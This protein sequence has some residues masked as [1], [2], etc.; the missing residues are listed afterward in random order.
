MLAAGKMMMSPRAEFIS[1]LKQIFFGLVDDT[2]ARGDFERWVDDHS[3]D[4][5]EFLPPNL[6]WEI[7]SADYTHENKYLDVMTKLA[8]WIDGSPFD[9]W[10]LRRLLTAIIMD[11]IDIV[12]AARELCGLYHDGGLIPVMLGVG[13]ASEFDDV[14]AACEYDLWDKSSLKEKL[15]KVEFYKDDFI[16]DARELLER[17]DRSAVR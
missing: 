5:E 12:S 16:R 11:R 6:S 3:N 1:S 2:L 4:I 8:Q 10:R 15:K 17:L 13:Y 9:T 7:L 14:P